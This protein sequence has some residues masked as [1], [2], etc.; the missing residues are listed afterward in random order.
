MASQVPLAKVIA[1]VTWQGVQMDI[2][3]VECVL[4][5]LIFDGLVKGYLSHQ[6][7]CLVLS[8]KDPFPKKEN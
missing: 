1:A 6:M 3:E 2:D 8:A 4:A 5:T 7:S